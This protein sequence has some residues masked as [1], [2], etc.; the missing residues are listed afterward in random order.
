MSWISRYRLKLY[1]NNSIW[2]LPLCGIIVGLLSVEN[3][4]TTLP[5]HRTA[6]LRKELALLE[7]SARR[8]SP[9]AYDQE[10]AE[11]GDLQGMDSH[12]DE[13]EQSSNE[14]GNPVLHARSAS[15]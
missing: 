10:L 6:P 11:A 3:L 1:F 12:G 9:D 4:L 14:Y 7:G 13:D 2:I 15:D 5:R 8:S